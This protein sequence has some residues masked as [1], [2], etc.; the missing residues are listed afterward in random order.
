MRD[1]R[2][3]IGVLAAHSG[4]PRLET[5]PPLSMLDASARSVRLPPPV[6]LSVVSGAIIRLRYAASVSDA[7][8]CQL[9]LDATFR[10]PLWPFAPVVSTLTEVP[11]FRMRSNITAAAGSIGQ[12]GAATFH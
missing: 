11:A 5:L 6:F 12:L 1:T 4:V 7:P 10:S 3:A 9:T 8:P 2:L